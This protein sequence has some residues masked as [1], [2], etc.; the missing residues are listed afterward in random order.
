MS[1]TAVQGAETAEA[2]QLTEPP[3]EWAQKRL[4]LPEPDS[5]MAQAAADKAA[6][7]RIVAAPVLSAAAGPEVLGRQIHRRRQDFLAATDTPLLNISLTHERRG[8]QNHKYCQR[9][10]IRW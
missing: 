3:V 2:A 1:D 4:Y 7:A 9:K 5:N 6:E 8:L 10:N